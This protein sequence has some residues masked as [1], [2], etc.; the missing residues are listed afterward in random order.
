[1]ERRPWTAETLTARDVVPYADVTLSIH[2]IGC[3]LIRELNVWKIGARLADDPLQQLRFRCQ[4]CGVYADELEV[5]RRTS[6]VGEHLL[7]IPLK[8]R[9]WDDG[10]CEDHAAALRR[11]EARRRAL[12][13]K[14]R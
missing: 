2:C 3:K 11:A 9:F 5:R 7:M 13:A 4:R 10:H 14:T 1:M 8:P 12:T 6:S